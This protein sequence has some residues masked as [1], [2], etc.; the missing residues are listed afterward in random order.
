MT[1]PI[2]IP[3]HF[4]IVDDSETNRELLRRRLIN[5]G[6]T[7]A[8][9]ANGRE[10]VN[11]MREQTFDIVLLDIMMPEMSGYEV[12]E[13]MKADTDLRHIPVIM[14]SSV[15]EIDSVVRCIEMGADDYLPKPF[16][17]ILLRARIGALLEK[18][19]LR[20]LEQ[21]HLREIDAQRKRADD[22]LRVILPDTI[23]E[24]LKAT[25]AIKPRRHENVAIMFCDIVGFTSYCDRRDPEE[26]HSYLQGLI[27]SFEEIALRHNLEKIKTIGDAFMVTAGLLHPLENP[28][29]NCVKCGL[30]MVA[31]TPQMPPHWQ[32][33]VGIHIGPVIAGVVGHRQYVFDVWG[34]TVNTAARLEGYGTSNAVNLSGPAY[35]T[36]RT[37]VR[38][39]ARHIINVKGKGDLDVY[40]VD[41][42]I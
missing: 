14:I 30:E 39:N 3:G 28:V 7:Y 23:V 21:A 17:P 25:N 36:V 10:A 8:L 24:E 9:A 15:D 34:D 4:L 18:K 38:T 32:L 11:Q 40:V 13:Y 33:R 27:E 19:R 26:V 35:D 22:L 42:L 29:L 20:D 16:Y 41:G 31:R 5:Q 1:A 2:S 6:H 12:L 37:L